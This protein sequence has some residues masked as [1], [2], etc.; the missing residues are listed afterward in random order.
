MEQRPSTSW[1]S[2]KT[3]RRNGPSLCSFGI[4][5]L[6]FCLLCQFQIF[7]PAVTTPSL[8]WNCRQNVKCRFLGPAFTKAYLFLCNFAAPSMVRSELV[9]CILTLMG[10]V[11][12]SNP[13]TS[14][15]AFLSPTFAYKNQ[16]LFQ[17]EF[18]YLRA[19]S[20]SGCSVDV[21]FQL[22]FDAKSKVDASLKYF[23]SKQWD[24]VNF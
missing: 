14:C 19:L 16:S 6:R 23:V 9:P 13:S 11:I 7:E 24:W 2:L 17:E 20:N 22:L 3:S 5:L 15:G 1:R 8:F 21:A 4:L 18:G 10:R 12:S